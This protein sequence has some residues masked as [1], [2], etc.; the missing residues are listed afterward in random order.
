MQF[1]NLYHESSASEG[2]SCGTVKAQISLN[3]FLTHELGA[4]CSSLLEKKAI[5]VLSKTNLILHL[6]RT[7]TLPAT[8]V[9][10]SLSSHRQAL[11]YAYP[12]ASSL[13]NNQAIWSSVCCFLFWDRSL[14]GYMRNSKNVTMLWFIYCH[15]SGSFPDFIIKIDS[16]WKMNVIIGLYSFDGLFSPSVSAYAAVYE[17]WWFVRTF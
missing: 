17:T 11:T 6:E 1:P 16:P 9:F 4:I 2:Y 12:I 5:S 7:P 15:Q 13:W 10:L 8:S 14:E 3:L